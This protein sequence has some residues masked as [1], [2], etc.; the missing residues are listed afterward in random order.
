MIRTTISS[1]TTHTHPGDEIC[2][3]HVPPSLPC[4]DFSIRRHQRDAAH[5]PP[6]LSPS[7]FP[8]GIP[9]GPKYVLQR[10]EPTGENDG[11][12]DVHY[13]SRRYPY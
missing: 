7:A 11:A 3:V 4:D 5:D 1:R 8:R 10:L 6:T 12:T 2:I 13:R 9:W